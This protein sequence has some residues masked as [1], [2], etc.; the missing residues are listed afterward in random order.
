[1]LLYHLLFRRSNHFVNWLCCKH[2][3]TFQIETYYSKA[4]LIL[5]ILHC[6]G[7]IYSLFGHVFLHPMSY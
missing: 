3:I 7:E 4:R 2:I 6:L 5:R 1:M